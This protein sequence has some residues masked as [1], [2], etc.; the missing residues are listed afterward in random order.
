[1]RITGTVAAL[2]V[3]LP[4]AAP[5]AAEEGWRFNV[6]PYVWAAG[7]DGRL[8]HHGLP[9]DI[10][11]EAKFRD[12]LGDLDIGAM[13]A[14]EGRKGR[15]G[16]LL[17]GLYVKVS[18]D[19]TMPLIG[20]PV[21]LGSTTFTGMAAGQYRIVDDAIGSFDLLAG[22]RY[23]SIT[24]RFSYEAPTGAPLPPGMPQAYGGSERASWVDAM[25]GAK[26]VAHITPGIT[27]NAHGMMGAG[28]SRL[29]SDALLAVGIG[30]GRSSSLLV[31]YRHVKA[32]YRKNGFGF[33]TS[34]H[35]PAMGLGF[36][37]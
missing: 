28:G 35:G 32:D 26:L 8:S 25:A 6:V 30:L 14:F 36:R 29:S 1:M 7:I 34:L 9:Q 31:G 24:S 4:L 33:D 21:S 2:A 18:R 12:V 3:I 5:A 17:D 16:F 10:D 22:V 23:W 37:F 19:A 11:V 13:L 27:L 15:V 20:L